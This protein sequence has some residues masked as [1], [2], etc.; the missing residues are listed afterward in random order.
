MAPDTRLDPCPPSPKEELRLS[1]AEPSRDSSLFTPLC[2]AV[3]TRS[4]PPQPCPKLGKDPPK[5]PSPPPIREPR[6]A[7]SADM[8][9]RD[10]NSRPRPP[11]ASDLKA[12]SWGVLMRFLALS[13]KP[14]MR[15]RLPFSRLLPRPPVA[16]LAMSSTLFRLKFFRPMLPKKSLALPLYRKE[17]NEP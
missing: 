8:T 13:M 7:G 5:F 16:L 14:L 12:P 3:L 4:D 15:P 2:T 10:R 9:P 1:A 6:P 17:L 11:V